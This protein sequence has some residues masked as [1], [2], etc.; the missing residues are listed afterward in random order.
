MEKKTLLLTV[1][2]FGITLIFLSFFN[3]FIPRTGPVDINYFKLVCKEF[4]KK[5]CES[6]GSLP[7]YWNK[8]SEIIENGK[9]IK[10]SCEEV[11]NCTSCY[12]CRFWG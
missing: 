11:L 9:L 7:E 4:G 8:T 3:P 12:E 1:A 10:K 2:I 5:S 6:I